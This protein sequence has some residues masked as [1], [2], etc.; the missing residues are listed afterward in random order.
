MTFKISQAMNE[1]R[2]KQTLLDAGVKIPPTVYFY[3]TNSS[4]LLVRGTKEQLALVYQ[5]VL[6]LN[7]VSPQ[8]AEK[9][10][11]DFVKE[12]TAMTGVNPVATNLEM[13][14]FKVDP[15]SFPFNLRAVY[16]LKTNNVV[17]VAGSLFNKLG[18]D[19]TAPGRS[20]TF[21]DKLG[22]L[23][24]KATAAE[25]DTIEL[26]VQA[27]NQIN[28]QIHIKAWFIEVPKDGFAMPQLFS[29]AVAGPMTGI[30][31]DSE[32]R[33]AL[34]VLAPQQG[35]VMLAEPECV[36]TSGRQTQMRATAT[37]LILTNFALQESPSNSTGVVPQSGKFEIGPAVDVV[38]WVL[39]DGYTIYL[40]TIVSEL[41][42]L[43]YDSETNAVFATNSI[44][45]KIHL[46]TVLPGFRV[47]K[48][49]AH[50]N[51]W[52]N[53]TL[54]LG[55]LKSNFVGGDGQIHNESKLLRDAEKKN[56]TA[57][58]ELLVFITATIVDPAGNR[59]HSDD[60]LPFNPATIPPQPKIPSPSP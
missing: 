60:D 22:L 35:V 44:G 18:V 16:D 1:A 32:F 43:G 55:N 2:L 30:L 59:V 52:D 37:E 5:A 33:A 15:H 54:V 19:L 9:V 53:Q 17:A 3:D 39:S 7:G 57:D 51:L 40:S 27:L 24:V 41:I 50:V 58:K 49:E 56:G 13:R 48:A 46:P 28:P 23:F 8:Q 47:Q 12:K 6:K 20:I 36:T 26:V 38:P 45:E 34:Q 14:V 31:S 25:L 29:N 42:F 4:I 10:V 21:N 11:N